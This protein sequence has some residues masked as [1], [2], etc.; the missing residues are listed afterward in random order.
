M[1][2]DKNW[3]VLT[4]G[5]GDLSFSASIAK[6]IIPK[7]LVATVFDHKTTLID[8]YSSQ[9]FEQLT[10]ANITVL[11]GFDVTDPDSW[12]ELP[13]NSFDLVIFQF[14]LVPNDVTY[15]QHRA[16]NALGSSNT[17]NRW[18][19]HRFLAHCFD[20]FLAK[21]GARLAMIT[22]K[23]VKPYRQ[24]AIETSIVNNLVCDYIGQCDFDF[25]DY[26]DYHIRN[27]DRD[28]FVK[29]TQAI[30]YFYSDKTQLPVVKQLRLPAYCIDDNY[31]AMCRT[32]PI[33]TKQDWLAHN[34]SKRHRQMRDFETQW[35]HR[36]NNDAR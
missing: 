28:K 35:Q 36:L 18:L 22:S 15:Q 27:V 4:I 11:T 16:S 24:W 21:D 12:Q 7:Q 5:D 13:A 33:E 20:T 17:I 32:G 8:K 2:I 9:H 30:S 1:F 29:V 25:N 26:P 34:E 6:H 10:A 14:P 19:L 31:C 23:D 3:R